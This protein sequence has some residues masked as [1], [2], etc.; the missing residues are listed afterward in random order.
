[1]KLTEIHRVKSIT[2]AEFVKNYLKPQKPVVIENLIGDWPA[3]DKWSLDYIKEI[4]GDKE[5]PLYD[6]RPVTH[7]D[8]FNQAHAKMKM[9]N[10]IDLL[11]R[12]PTNYRIFLY[13]IMKEV[14]LLKKDFK[15]P[16]IGLRLIKQIPMVFFGGENSKVF[17]HHDID[18]ANILHFHF[19]GK[20][21]CILFPPDQT[22]NL[23]KVPHS[24]ITREDI[25][26]DHPDYEKFPVLKKAE[27]LVC[28][29]KHGETLYMPEGYWHYMK[30]LTPGFSMSLRALPRKPKH[31]LKAVYNVFIMR[32][33]DNLMRRR[34][35][36]AWIDEKNERAIAETH[37]KHG[38]VV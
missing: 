26:F 3:Y 1:M 10:Y 21:R 38:L 27:G 2:K 5:V 15:F 17:M 33:F 7:E 24:L 6:D 30:Y 4:A 14:P 37:E 29:L 20:K 23:Y 22:E 35:G 13:N 16:K 8:G 18:W 34:K 36:Q 25:D 28:D 32:H 9:A 11:K 12:E 31:L 19:H